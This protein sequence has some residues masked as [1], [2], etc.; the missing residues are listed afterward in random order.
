MHGRRGARQAGRAQRCGSSAQGAR[1][2]QAT[3]GRRPGRHGVG[4]QGCAAGRTERAGHG[5]PGRG[6]GAG[7]VCRLGQLGQFLCT[8][9]LAQFWL[10]FWTRFDSVFFL[11][12]QMNTVH[13]KNK[14]KNFRKK[15]IF[16]KF[17]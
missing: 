17:K 1:D 9:H 12:H 11:S 7:W 6:L 10:G 16:I 2:A 4:A 8:E 3:G 5:L 15:I 14:N 13:C